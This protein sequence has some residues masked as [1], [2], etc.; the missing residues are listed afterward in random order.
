MS[1]ANWCYFFMLGGFCCWKANWADWGESQTIKVEVLDTL[2]GR[3]NKLVTHICTNTLLSDASGKSAHNQF[4]IHQ[5]F[6]DSKTF[7]EVLVGSESVLVSSSIH[8]SYQ[9]EQTWNS[10]V[11]KVAWMIKTCWE[12]STPPLSFTRLKMLQHCREEIQPRGCLKCSHL[13]YFLLLI[14]AKVAAQRK[15]ANIKN[16]IYAWAAKYYTDCS[17]CICILAFSVSEALN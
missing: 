1:K 12:K 11:I 5:N 14:P 8:S 7:R 9:K 6:T 2:Q 4:L 13:H 3:R 10:S 17:F 16:I 15:C